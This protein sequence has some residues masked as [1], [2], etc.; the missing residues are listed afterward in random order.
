MRA[1]KTTRPRTTAI[2]AGWEVR[3]AAH[4]TPSARIVAAESDRR[5]KRPRTNSRRQNRKAIW[6]GV[7]AKLGAAAGAEG[8]SHT[9]HLPSRRDKGAAEALQ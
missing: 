7:P 8:L 1:C 4:Q 3:A 9:H 2:L 6:R 5:P